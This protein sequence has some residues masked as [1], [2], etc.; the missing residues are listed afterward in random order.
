MRRFPPIAFAILLLA[1]ITLRAE[2]AAIVSRIK[3]VPVESSAVATVGY[4]KKLRALEIEF[5]NGSIYRYL[6]VP[7]DVYE[8]LLNARSKARYYDENIRHKYRSQHVKSRGE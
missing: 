1:A 5:R 4:S 3:H 2:P 8:A 6:D 7:T